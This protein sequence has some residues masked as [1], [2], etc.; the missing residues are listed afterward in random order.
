MSRVCLPKGGDVAAP[1]GGLIPLVQ[2][3]CANNAP[4]MVTAAAFAPWSHF[5]TGRAGNKRAFPSHTVLVR[6]G[7][8]G[9]IGC[10]ASE[11][12]EG[13]REAR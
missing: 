10:A 7:I 12:I 13:Q 4:A 11:R 5:D 2:A 3:R 8:S 6:G 9:Q 1:H